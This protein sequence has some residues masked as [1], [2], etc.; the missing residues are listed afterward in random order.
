MNIN[1]KPIAIVLGAA[2]ALTGAAAQASVFQTA[3]LGAGYMVASAGDAKT[4]EAKCGEGKCGDK[5]GA[6]AKA[7]GTCGEG[8]CGEGKCGEPV[9]KMMDTNADGMVSKDEFMAMHK[10]SEGKCGEGKCGEKKTEGKC[11]EGKCGEKK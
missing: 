9:F 10:R 7:E 8:K 4:G 2:F 1:R 6:K 3:D 11:G 5:M